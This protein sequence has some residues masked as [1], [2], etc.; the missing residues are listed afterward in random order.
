MRYVAH[1]AFVRWLL[2][3][4][5]I[6]FLLTVAPSNLTPLMLVRSF[7]AGEQ[8][9]VVNLAV[10]EIVFSIGHG[11]RRHRGGRRSSPSA[12]GSA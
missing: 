12:A 6:I 1:H 2:V 9:N 3:L 11:A 7:D 10:L 8:Q 4:F 5:A